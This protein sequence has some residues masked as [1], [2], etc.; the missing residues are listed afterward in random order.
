MLFSRGLDAS[1]EGSF[2]FTFLPT[3]KYPYGGQLQVRLKESDTTYYELFNTDGYGPGYLAKV[4]NGTEVERVTLE[5]AYLQNN[6]YTVTITFSPGLTSITGFGTTVSLNTD[7]TAINVQSFSID[8]FQ[9]TAY[10]DDLVYSIG[11]EGEIQ[12][13]LNTPQT[14]HIQTGYA[15]TATAT[16]GVLQRE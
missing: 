5:S 14:G 13:V 15:V 10:Y 7:T 3:V 4:V 9:Q 8:S 12:L 1:T 16:A 2:S 6:N 11:E